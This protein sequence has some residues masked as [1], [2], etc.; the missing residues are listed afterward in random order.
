VIG[1][2]AG[3]VGLE[4]MAECPSLTGHGRPRRAGGGPAARC[5]RGP[6]AGTSWLPWSR[7]AP[8]LTRPGWPALTG[9][10]RPDTAA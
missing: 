7:V 9:V 3:T 1:C 10:P 5:R 6:T 8:V 2:V 4:I